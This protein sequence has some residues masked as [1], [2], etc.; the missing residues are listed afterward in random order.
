MKVSPVVKQIW[1][2][3]GT[4]TILVLVYALYVCMTHHP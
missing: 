4:I 1:M 3:T 2:V